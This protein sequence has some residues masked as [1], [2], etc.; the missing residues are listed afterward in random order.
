MNDDHLEPRLTRTAVLRLAGAGAAGLAL[1]ARTGTRRTDRRGGGRGRRARLPRVA[2]TGRPR[3]GV[4]PVRGRRAHPL[5]LD[6]ACLGAAERPSARSDVGRA[7]EARAR[8]A[9]LEQLAGRLP[10]VARHHGAAGRAAAH[11]HG[12][13][14]SVRPR[15]LLRLGVRH[16]RGPSV[17]LAVR[18]AP[19]L[20]ALHRRRRHPRR[21]AV[22]PRR[23][24]D[25][26]GERVPLGRPR[27]PDDAARGGRRPGDRALARRPAPEAGG[28]LVGVA[29]RPPHPERRPGEPAR[30]GG[31]AH[32][33]SPVRGAEARARDPAHVPREPSACSGARA[34]SPGSSG[35]ASAARASAGP[36]ALAPACPIT[37]GCRDRPSCSSS[38]TRGTAAPT[39]TASGAISS[40]TSAAIFFSVAGRRAGQ[41]TSSMISTSSSRR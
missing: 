22:L 23:L 15:P 27:L 1:G 3:P 33:R 18:G 10:Q 4:V 32:G 12:V 14:R 17:G 16:A 21:R 7:A 28:V 13:Q 29:H 37:T 19:S 34:R 36:A 40:A 20:E 26:R 24:A 35:R 9:A 31:R 38:T 2:V 6:G 41:P 8:A 25:P 5:A 39:S 30:A 11:E